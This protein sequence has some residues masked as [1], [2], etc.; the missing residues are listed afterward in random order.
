MTNDVKP[1]VAVLVAAYN[2]EATLERAVISACRQ[3]I[4]VEVIVVDDCSTDE[5]F[6]IAE[7]CAK[8]WHCVQVYRQDQNAGPAAARNR[9][10]TVSRAPWIAVL[11]S[12]DHMAPD[13]L[14][15]L[16]AVAEEC[17][18]D[19]VAD[20]LYRVSEEDLVATDNR[21]WSI[22]DFGQV[23]VTFEIFVDGNLRKFGRRGELGFLKPLMRR[24]FLEDHDLRYDM[25][26]RLAEDYILYAR[27]LA[28]GCRFKL[29][30]P[31][32][33]FAVY[34][35]NSLSS[36]HSTRDLQEIVMADRV[37]AKFPTLSATEK[38]VLRKHRIE[39]HKE[40]AWR[41]LIDAVNGRD[42]IA[43]AKLMTEPPVVTLSVAWKLLEQLY[44]RSRRLTSSERSVD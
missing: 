25:K 34:R 9:A 18:F 5:T 26:L 44:I 28:S 12:D 8:A 14:E 41:Q 27:A 1:V 38:A 32:G 2:A 40:W 10:M 31:K 4:P 13:R 3:T 17:Q 15:K 6:E 29:I 30:D 20:D 36:R 16:V 7:A 33:Y 39:V 24:R 11:D 19:F 37:L 43:M 23:D 21:L 35:D 42:L 22:S